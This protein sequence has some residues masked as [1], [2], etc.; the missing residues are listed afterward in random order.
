MTQMRVSCES[1][2]GILPSV[3]KQ[4]LIKLMTEKVRADPNAWTTFFQQMTE[5]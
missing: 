1:K 2:L 3:D 5:I 4:L